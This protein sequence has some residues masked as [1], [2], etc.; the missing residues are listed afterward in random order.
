MLLALAGSSATASI[1]P[2]KWSDW[3]DEYVQLE[4][5]TMAAFPDEPAHSDVVNQIKQT[6]DAIQVAE[7]SVRREALAER[8][9]I[10]LATIQGQI[11]PDEAALEH[12]R[13]N[14]AVDIQLCY[15]YGNNIPRIFAAI[16]GKDVP[17]SLRAI[18]IVHLT[19]SDYVSM[20]KLDPI[21]GHWGDPLRRWS[22]FNLS[23]ASGS[24]Q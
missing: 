6:R 23:Q 19:H 4:K 10:A 11:N 3:K 24:E 22:P 9:A 5:K 12:T 15:I 14:S 16:F 1:D 21:Q 8:V 13:L 20:L 2:A 17:V 7:A 18:F